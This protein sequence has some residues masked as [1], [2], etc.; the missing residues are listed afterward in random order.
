MR[1]S[2]HA[3]RRP[4]AN[5]A[6]EAG[7]QIINDITG[8]RDDPS[9]IDVARESGSAVI[10]MHMLGSPKTMQK[11]IRYESFPKDIHDFFEIGSLCWSVPV[12]P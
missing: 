7:A 1:W 2:Y 4:V 10:V 9:M 8:F 12:S 11:E 5:V 6:I 3:R